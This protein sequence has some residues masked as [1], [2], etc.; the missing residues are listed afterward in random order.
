[1]T[2]DKILNKKCIWREVAES[3]DYKRKDE[4][5]KQY[6]T[7]KEGSQCIICHGYRLSCETY[8]PKDV[9]LL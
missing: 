5:R 1:M 4:Q 6:I 9:K 7:L 2:L 3:D 8:I